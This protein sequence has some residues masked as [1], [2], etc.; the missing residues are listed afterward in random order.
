MGIKVID[1]LPWEKKKDNRMELLEADIREIIEKRIH[2]CEI[3]DAQYPDGTIRDRLIKAI[4][5][6]IWGYAERDKKGTRRIPT[7]LFRVLAI[8]SKTID[9]KKH[10]YIT[11]DVNL[12]DE[13]W[14]T[15]GDKNR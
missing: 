11:F 1:E 12:W 2:V 9:G 3:V 7:N 15:F 13:E 6:V 10:W 5:T 8:R 14:K 4:R